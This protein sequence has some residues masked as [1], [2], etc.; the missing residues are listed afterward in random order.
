MNIQ[1]GLCCFRLILFSTKRIAASVFS[2]ELILMG[3][4]WI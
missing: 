3:G 2:I 4:F 1:G